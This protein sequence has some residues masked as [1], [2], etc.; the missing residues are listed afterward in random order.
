[1]KRYDFEYASLNRRD[2][3]KWVKYE[4]VAAVSDALPKT[5]DGVSVVPGMEVWVNYEQYTGRTMYARGFDCLKK[6]GKEI[7]T[8][9]LEISPT[10]SDRSAATRIGWV[11]DVYSTEESAKMARI[12]AEL[13]PDRS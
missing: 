1:M 9:Y 8:F 5:A 3:G 2:N 4:D 11:G 10:D 12:G 6:S 7:W 13:E